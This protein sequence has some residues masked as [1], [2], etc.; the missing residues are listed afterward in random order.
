MPLIKNQYNEIPV[1]EDFEKLRIIASNYFFFDDGEAL[2][3]GQ[4]FSL[5]SVNLVVL[6]DKIYVT[7]KTT[8]NVSGKDGEPHEEDKATNADEGGGYGNKGLDGECGGSSG[9]VL[10]KC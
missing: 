6:A 9:N 5:E 2:S 10:I 8:I 7:E 1:K 4:D 3:N